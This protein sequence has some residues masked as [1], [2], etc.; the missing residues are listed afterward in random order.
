LIVEVKKRQS[1]NNQKSPIINRTLNS[2]DRASNSQKQTA[3][4]LIEFE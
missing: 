3:D 1:I 4:H 2:H